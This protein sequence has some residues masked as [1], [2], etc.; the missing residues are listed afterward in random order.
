MTTDTLELLT[1]TEAEFGDL[2]PVQQEEYLRLLEAEKAAWSLRSTPKVLRAHVLSSKVDHLLMGGAAGGGKSEGMLYHAWWWSKQV[3]NHRSLIVRT[4]LGE[5]RRSLVPRS[6]MRFIQTGDALPGRRGGVANSGDFAVLRQQDN[7]RVWWFPNG[8]TI[9]MSYLDDQNVTDYL[10]AEY[11]FIGIDESTTLSPF[12]ISRIQ[13][14]LRTSPE[15]RA[16]GVRPHLMLATNPGSKSLAHHRDLYVI[17]TS[18][19]GDWGKWVTVYDISRGFSDNDGNVDWD[20]VRVA[21]KVPAPRTVAEVEDFHIEAD[22]EHEL[23][24]AFVQFFARDNPYLDA[25]YIR[26]LNALPERDRRRQLYGDWTVADDAF[27]AEFDV[28]VHLCSPFPIPDT[29]EVGIGA[30]YGYAK[31]YAAVA[32]AWDPDT[33]TAYVFGECYDVRLTAR[34]QAEQMQAMLTYTDDDGHEQHYRVRHRVADPSTF[35]SV[36]EGKAIADQWGEAGVRFDKAIRDRKSGWANVREYLRHDDGEPPKLFIM[37]G[38]VPNLVRELTDALTDKGNPEDLDTDQ[39]DHALD[40]LR[41]LLAQKP[42]KRR[43]KEV[44]PE[45]TNVVE[46]LEARNLERLRREGQRAARRGRVR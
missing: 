7:V 38:R 34:Q 26:N 22:S 1:L 42:R 21:R 36:G 30:D 28:K 33:D 12:A 9:E 20:K 27:F 11:E 23:V 32:V 41:Y 19:E 2:S 25:S 13:A 40:A 24:V 14:R 3:P 15:R 4:K 6:K 46:R 18:E 5:L 8:S 10:S 37:R 29:W 43:R 35:T 16:M 17:P 45:P 44:Q 39:S 31:P